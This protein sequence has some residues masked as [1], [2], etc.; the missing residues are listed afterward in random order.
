MAKRPEISVLMPFYD[1][2]KPEVRGYFREA[3]QSILN[4]TFRD[5]EVVLV[6]SGKEDFAKKEAA[7]SKKIRL[8]FFR[9]EPIEKNRPVSER[10]RGIVTARNL[11]LRH[12]RGKFIAWADADDISLPGRLEAQRNFLE[13]HPDI[14]LVGSSMVVIGE[15]GNEMGQLG[16]FEDNEKI[17]KNL[18]R[19]PTVYQPAVFTY[20]SLVKKAGGYRNELSED[21]DLWARMAAITQMHNIREPLVKYRM[22]P[23]G[24]S[25][26]KIDHFFSSQRIRWRIMKTLGIYPS[27]DG[28][29]L[30]A[31]YFASYF[32]PPFLGTGLFVKIRTFVFS[33]LCPELNGIVGGSVR[34]PPGKAHKATGKPL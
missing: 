27:W 2:G 28:M 14:G 23:G 24:S 30:D 12:A 21:Y 16:T 17:R 18:I 5:F 7:K 10:L 11:C 31:M 9:Q 34:V 20:L 22:H 3:L 4:Q 26:Y 6:V 29:L 13:A 19:F 25:P 32:Y 1:S 33:L 8:F 15:D